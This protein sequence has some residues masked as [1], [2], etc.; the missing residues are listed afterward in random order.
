MI[1]LR[2]GMELRIRDF[3]ASERTTQL[4][5][6]EELFAVCGCPNKRLHCT[7]PMGGGSGN[8]ET[9]GSN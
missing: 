7:L 8:G 6:G 2:F 3:R 4:L 5:V 1:L 9:G